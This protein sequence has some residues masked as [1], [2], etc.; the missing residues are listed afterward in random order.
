MSNRNN[1][2]LCLYGLDLTRTVTCDN[3]LQAGEETSCSHQQAT[4]QSQSTPH[5]PVQGM[6]TKVDFPKALSTQRTQHPFRVNSRFTGPAAEFALAALLAIVFVY[7]I[8]ISHSYN[9]PFTNEITHRKHWWKARLDAPGWLELHQQYVA[10]ASAAF[11]TQVLQMFCMLQ[12]LSKRFKD[13]RFAASLT[14]HDH[15]SS[16]L[17][18]NTILQQAHAAR[19]C[20]TRLLQ[21]LHCAYCQPVNPCQQN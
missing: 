20:S 18:H 3:L 17:A 9:P 16:V 5:C 8:T 10:E 4:E 6:V 21:L 11:A 7:T 19:N 2:N 13:A 14:K 12:V 15:S 1:D